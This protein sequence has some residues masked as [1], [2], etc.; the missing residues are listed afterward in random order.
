ML[1]KFLIFTKKN[2]IKLT[3]HEKIIFFIMIIGKSFTLTPPILNSC[4]CCF[5]N[6]F[7]FC[8]SSYQKKRCIFEKYLLPVFAVN[9]FLSGR[10]SSINDYIFCCWKKYFKIYV[11]A[12]FHQFSSTDKCFVFNWTNGSTI[13]FCRLQADWTLCSQPAACLQHA[14]S[15]PTACPGCLKF[16]IKL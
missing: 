9:Y 3:Y 14:C 15:V 1:K 16:I 8:C 5:Q 12:N 7:G 2:Q 11:W 10:F 6:S 4:P 13:G